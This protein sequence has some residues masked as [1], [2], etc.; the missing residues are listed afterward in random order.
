MFPASGK[1]TLAKAWGQ[2]TGTA[3]YIKQSAIDLS[4]ASS[5]SR[6]EVL[7][8]G[9]LLAD[10]LARLE[11]YAATPGLADYA[12]NELNDPSIDITAEYVTMRTEIVATQDWI[13]SNF[14]R[15]TSNNLVV[16]SFD[17]SKKFTD[18]TLT[19]PQLTAFMS[20]LTALIATID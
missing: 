2:V 5:I 1:V 11:Q 3:A 10:A 7:R 9:N 8:F 17:V 18:I 6:M 13:V 14:P 20:R 12:T 19:A 4:G 16:F 15:D